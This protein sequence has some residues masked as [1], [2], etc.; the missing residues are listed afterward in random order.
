[1]RRFYVFSVIFGL[2]LSLFSKLGSEGT[3]EPFHRSVDLRI[4]LGIGE[5]A[6]GA[7]RERKRH[8]LLIAP[9]VLPRVDIKHADVLKQRCAGLSG[10][11]TSDSKLSIRN[12]PPGEEYNSP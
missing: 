11:E 10:P 2:Y 4:Y 6:V 1:L 8:T 3:G 9:H 5:R 7:K 12:E